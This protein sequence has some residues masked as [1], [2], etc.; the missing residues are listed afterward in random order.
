MPT[1]ELVTAPATEPVTVAELKLHCRQDFA[2]DDALFTSLGVAARQWFEVALDRQ[3]VTASWKV[4]L[5]WFPAGDIEL[6]YPPLQSVTSI[7]YKDTAL[8]TQ[9]LSA[10]A[11]TAITNRT[12]GVVQLRDG[13]SWPSTGTDVLAVVVTFVAGYGAAAAVPDLIKAGIKL[14]VGHWYERR[15][16]VGDKAL[17]SVPFAADAIVQAARAY[18]F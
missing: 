11:Y 1:P 17:A 15:E 10:A 14:L 16:A 18:R 8:V 5:P 2:D 13:Y 6:P 7:T 3:L 12:P 9:T 4:R